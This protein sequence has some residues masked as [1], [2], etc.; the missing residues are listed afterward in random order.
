MT[1]GLSEADI[2]RLVHA[3][4]HGGS[5]ALDLSFGATRLR[6]GAVRAETSVE[7]VTA[8][9]VGVFCAEV[10][11]GNT[12]Q[13]DSILG[14]IR[15]VRAET[16]VRAGR[17]GVITALAAADGDFVEYNARLAEIRIGAG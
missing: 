11:P 2:A 1:V 8:P 10:A 16:P 12:V 5:A 7:P 4:R 3:F 14:R 17:A 6:L 15:S 9:M 13:P